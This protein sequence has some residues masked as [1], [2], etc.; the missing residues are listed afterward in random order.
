MTMSAFMNDDE[1]YNS[2]KPVFYEYPIMYR[3][4]D[5]KQRTHQQSHC[6]CKQST[7]ALL[8]RIVVYILPRVF[9]TN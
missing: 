8:D 6:Y 9:I 7:R 2:H 1:T 5:F 4:G 3:Y